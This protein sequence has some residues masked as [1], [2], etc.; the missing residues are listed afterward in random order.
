MARGR[1]SFD[2]H[3]ILAALERHYVSY[4]VIGGLAQVLRGVDQLTE[5]VDI[6]PSFARDNL[7][8]LDRAAHELDARRIDGEP[9]TLS[10]ETIGT[11]AVISLRTS[12]GLLQVIGA[13]AGAPRGYVDLRRAASAEHLGQGIQP[14]IASTG[15]LARM[16]AAL[17][18]D[19]DI[20]RLPELR[21][22]IE[23][24]ADKEVKLASPLGS[25]RPPTLRPAQSSRRLTR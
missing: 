13:P 19:V 16:A 2:P 1:I 22:I 17:H 6:C 25:T 24:E 8:R 10:D 18:R 14:L 4:V 3:A 20:E 23:L 15:D 12:A 5:G 9:L 11:E 7:D 21:R